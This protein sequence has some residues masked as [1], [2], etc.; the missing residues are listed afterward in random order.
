MFRFFRPVWA[1]IITLAC[2]GL[3]LPSHAASPLASPRGPQS[4]SDRAFLAA[5][6]ANQQDDLIGLIAAAEQLPTDYA[7]ADYVAYWALRLQLRAS[8]IPSASLAKAV[9]RFIADHPHAVSGDLMRRQWMLDLAARDQ[10]QEMLSLLPQWRRRNDTRVYCRAGQA[11]MALGQAPGQDALRGLQRDRDLGSECGDFAAQLRQAGLL[12]VDD[13]RKRM[14]R[15]LELR[16]WPSV[17]LL[18]QMRGEQ[19]DQIDKAITAPLKL[20]GAIEQPEPQRLAGPAST[21]AKSESRE[22]LLIAIV[23]HSRLKPEEAAQWMTHSGTR[24]TESEQRFIWS[25][26]AAS[27]MRDMIAPAIDY[28]RLAL[29]S[30]ATDVTRQWLA[31]AALREHDWTLLLGFIAEMGPATQRRSTWMYWRARAMR[32]MGL[33]TSADKLLRAIATKRDFYGVLAAEELGMLV[34]L[35]AQQVI[36]PG[37]RAIAEAAALPGLARARLFYRLGLTYHGNREWSWQIRGL[38]DQR[39]LA[40]AHYACQ[41]QLPERCINTAFRT[42]RSHDWTLRF[43]KPFRAPVESIA[44]ARGLD[45]A[46]IYGL[47]HQ[48]SR[49]ALRARSHV[50]A[51][52]LMQ[53]MPRTGRWIA[54]QLGVR[55]FKTAQLEQ[56]ETNVAFGTYYLRSVYDKLDQSMLLA[57]AAYNAGPKRPRRWRASLPHPVDGALFAELIPFAQTR[58]YVKKVLLNTAYYGYRFEGKPQ[59]L[60][61]LLGQV[62]NLPF[63]PLSMP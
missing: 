51:R 5:Y 1:L 2:S 34:Q 25:Q 11:R 20:L 60:K 63:E 15:A 54:R 58:Q 62:A 55:G 24:F 36:K 44:N 14:W 37:A 49:F 10:W 9:R 6:R 61:R 22:A 13:L 7:L 48:E 42:R 8:H 12:T 27:A 52:G 46:W 33:A 59:S 56:F 43:M 28:A 41:L 19:E 47:M 30:S 32:E 38:S 31:R 4:A 17:R 26:I 57:S 29:A 16:D 45:P 21:L 39:L 23:S 40:V 53:I 3:A 50:G 18:A 35:P